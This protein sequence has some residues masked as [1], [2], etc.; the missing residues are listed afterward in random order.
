VP[1]V[2]SLVDEKTLDEGYGFYSKGKG[3]LNL[4]MKNMK[5]NLLQKTPDNS[6]LLIMESSFETAPEVIRLN[7]NG[8][9]T[10]ICRT[11][12]QQEKFYWGKS[13]LR[14]FSTEDG[15]VQKS[16]LFYP[17]N[18]VAGRKYPLIVYIYERMSGELNTYV[19][20]SSQN[21]LGFNA[22]NYTTDGY[23]VL[24]P[25]IKYE[26]NAPGASA[27]KCVMAAVDDV[28]ATEMIDP[29]KIGLV[30]HSFG[31]YETAYIISHC[32]RFRVAVAGAPITDLQGWY[33]SWDGYQKSNIWRFEN[34]QFRLQSP[35]YSMEFLE[36]SP[37]LN[38][39]D[40]NT[41]VLIWTASTDKQV[42]WT[43]SLKLYTGLWRLGKQS[44]LLI[45]PDD[46]HILLNPNHQQD[47]TLRM[48]EWLAKYLK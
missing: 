6:Y 3:I 17:A 10:L 19:K 8:S 24:Y 38:I 41:P 14:H 35:F 20:P 42:D 13:E 15:D 4:T 18:Y 32:D 22:T 43:N 45:Y 7:S 36:N 29:E 5:M 1:I 46:E 31:G 11:N 9:Q 47:L 16:A 12:L 39:Q 23:F 25:D 21:R 27:L 40:I 33:L 30:G 2:L 44:T 48:R 37:I 28:V 34:Q 26:L